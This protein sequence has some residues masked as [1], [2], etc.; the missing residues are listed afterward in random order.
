M[1][2]FEFRYKEEQGFEDY[3]SNNWIE[4]ELSNTSLKDEHFRVLLE[5]LWNDRGQ[6]I[7]FICR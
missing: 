7:P 4:E 1:D 2:S 6:T 5:Q 3:L